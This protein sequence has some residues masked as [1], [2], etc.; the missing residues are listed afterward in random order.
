[1]NFLNKIS[2]FALVALVMVAVVACQKSEEKAPAS[3]NMPK[4]ANENMTIRYV[5]A[6]TLLK[7]YNLAKDFNESA[8]RM[9][10]QLDALQKTQ[11]DKI[12]NLQASFAQ[13]EK[14]NVYATNPQQAQADQAAYQNAMEAAQKAIA[15]KQEEIAK[16]LEDNQKEL[17][18]KISKFLEEYAKEKGYDMILNKAAT[19][20]VDPKFDVTSDVVEQ[21]N[22]QYTKV[23]KPQDTKEEAPKK[24]K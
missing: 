11:E 19:F 6:D 15:A 10:N 14:N 4:Q 1:M 13:K 12:R 2:K 9:Q 5:D 3:A 18:D 17:N 22:K 7:F 16:V 23:A 8:T 24:D 21:L 20:Y